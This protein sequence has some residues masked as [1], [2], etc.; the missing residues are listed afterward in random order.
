[1]YPVSSAGGF[2]LLQMKLDVRGCIP[3]H[4]LAVGLII[5][6]LEV[7]ILQGPPINFFNCLSNTPAS[8][9]CKLPVLRLGPN[10]DRTPLNHLSNGLDDSPFSF[11]SALNELASQVTVDRGKPASIGFSSRL[12]RRSLQSNLAA[13]LELQ[14]TDRKMTT[15]QRFRTI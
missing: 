12:S 4:T 7:R 13:R 11:L 3:I 9:R 1:M 15:N 5:L 10:W 8:F 6:W 14:R 2:N